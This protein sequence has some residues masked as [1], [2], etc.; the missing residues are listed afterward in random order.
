MEF[1]VAMSISVAHPACDQWCAVSER[2]SLVRAGHRHPKISGSMFAAFD[3]SLG[4]WCIHENDI[5]RHG[6]FGSPL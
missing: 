6:A 1:T 2:D 3:Q 5:S 4:R